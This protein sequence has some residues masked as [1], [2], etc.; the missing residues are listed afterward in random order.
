MNKL[1]NTEKM[2]VKRFL[3]TPIPQYI[4]EYSDESFDLLDCYEIAFTYA[5][6]ILRCGEINP[7]YSPWGDG[8]SVIFDERY[9][10]L[11][12]KIKNNNVS[13]EISRYCELFLT[14]IKIFKMH[15]I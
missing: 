11:L 13:E 5:N 14:I 7:E 6:E 15:L 12:I 2:I 10:Q 9:S 8:N 1:N 4:Y 3:T